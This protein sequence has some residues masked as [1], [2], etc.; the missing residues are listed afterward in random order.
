MPAPLHQVHLD[1]R[2]IRD[3]DEE[4]PFLRNGTNT[5][6]RYIARERVKGVEDWPYSRMIGAPHNLP[7]ITVITDVT[8]PCQRLE[9]DSEA[10]RLRP[11]AQLPQV[12]RC[13]VDPAQ[14]V[15]RNVAASSPPIS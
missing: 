2:H 10:S 5:V 13:A 9:A 7:C 6:Y 12:G 14:R 1:P 11:L 3:L 4:Y 8:T 15:R